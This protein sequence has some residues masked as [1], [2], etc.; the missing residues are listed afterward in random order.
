MEPEQNEISRQE[1]A[2]SASPD[3]QEKPI[4]I[5]WPLLV[6]IVLLVVISVIFRIADSPWNNRRRLE[7]NARNKL[8]EL[9]SA[10]LAYQ[11]LNNHKYYG[12]LQALQDTSCVDKSATLNSLIEG[13][14]VGW[15]FFNYHDNPSVLVAF[16]RNTAFT[17]VAYPTNLS[18]PLLRTFGI[19]EDQILRIY[20]P[21]NSN[22][23]I[24]RNDPHVQS[25]DPIL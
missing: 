14:E 20:N 11:A 5:F 25:W 22:P 19:S 1:P 16:M 12:S 15:D 17:I 4:N 23:F 6:G 13:Y 7:S 3:Q 24:N 18:R 2:E 9:G 8:R 10:Q 21:E